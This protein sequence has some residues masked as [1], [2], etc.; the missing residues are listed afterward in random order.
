M[1]AEPCCGETAAAF[2]P[3]RVV[4]TR[5]LERLD[6]RPYTVAM[7][8]AA[9]APEREDGLEVLTEKVQEPSPE[10]H[11]VLVGQREA[12]SGGRAAGW[13][14]LLPAPCPSRAGKAFACVLLQQQGLQAEEEL[15]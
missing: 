10:Q 11:H 2:F 4:L 1:N 5:C 15:V 6:C 12:R 14:R 13:Q 9:R 7:G 8:L 3:H